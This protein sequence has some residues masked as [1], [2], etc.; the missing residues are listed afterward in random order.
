MFTVSL[1]SIEFVARFPR[2]D[3]FFCS[4]LVTGGSR[5]GNSLVSPIDLCPLP[6]ICS[7]SSNNVAQDPIL[8]VRR[9]EVKSRLKNGVKRSK[10]KNKAKSLSPG[11]FSLSLLG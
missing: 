7:V 10:K 4:S 6:Y 11:L 5:L 1:A 3:I 9:E 2:K 8:R